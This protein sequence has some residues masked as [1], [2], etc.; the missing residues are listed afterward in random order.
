MLGRHI[1]ESN[2]GNG[3]RSYDALSDAL[4][5]R[6]DIQIS[7]R[8]RLQIPRLEKPQ[9][10][11]RCMLAARQYQP[12]AVIS[13]DWIVTEMPRRGLPRRRRFAQRRQISGPHLTDR[14]IDTGFLHTFRSARVLRAEDLGCNVSGG[15]RCGGN[16]SPTIRRTSG[17]RL[18]PR[19]TSLAF[20][21]C[22]RASSTLEKRRA[23]R[24]PARRKR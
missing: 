7:G 4:P 5:V 3:C 1:A 2:D 20:A 10:R 6:H 22:P 8:R 9:R 15:R 21:R 14:W 19:S 13:V 12:C 16:S 24:N 18:S 23:Y 17:T 11:R